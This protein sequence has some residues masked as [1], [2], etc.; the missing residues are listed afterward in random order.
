MRKKSQFGFS[1]IELMVVVAIAM[2]LMAMAAPMIR[3]VVSTY[4]L[5][6]AANSYANLLQNARMRAVQ[7]DQYHPVWINSGAPP[8]APIANAC[9]DINASA[10][11]DWGA[12]GAVAEPSVA[13]HA[14]VQIQPFQAP[15]APNLNNLRGQY[16]PPTCGANGGCVDINPDAWGPTFGPRGLPCEAAAE[17]GAACTYLSSVTGIGPAGN[18]L[19]TAFETY[20]Q[21]IR[22]GA[23]QA[24][25][26]SPAGRVRQ[27]SY[28]AVAGTWTPLD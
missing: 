19:P 11:C 9:V 24:V 14:T 26:V 1:M 20:L 22:T 17:A 21:N 16:L 27:W 28:N 2:I 6:T 7:D 25:T 4:H 23:W 13:F 3:N 5:R 15:A 10:T 8:T 12:A 18:N